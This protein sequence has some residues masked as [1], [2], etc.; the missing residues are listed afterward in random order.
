MSERPASRAGS[1]AFFFKDKR[2]QRDKKFMTKNKNKVRGVSSVADLIRAAQKAQQV[3][4]QKH[5]VQ[6]QLFR[7]EVTNDAD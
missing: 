6:L 3:F 4:V 2:E 1:G 5:D 7:E